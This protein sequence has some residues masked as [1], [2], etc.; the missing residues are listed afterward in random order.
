MGEATEKAV[1][2]QSDEAALL[3]TWQMFGS[4]LTWATEIEKG[5][6]RAGAEQALGDLPHITAL[7]ALRANAHLVGLLAGRRWYV[8]QAAREAGAT[9]DEIGEALGMSR[10]G[11]YDSYRRKIRQREEYVPE[12]HD[13]ARARSALGAKTD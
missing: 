11:A 10:Q 9:W 7:D 12:I 13:T 2:E 3:N 4:R 6:D 8:M 5:A 1:H